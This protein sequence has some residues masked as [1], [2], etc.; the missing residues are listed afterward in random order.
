MNPCSA[1]DL[2][3]QNSHPVEIGGSLWQELQ[4]LSFGGVVPEPIRGQDDHIPWLDAHVVQIRILRGGD[5]QGSGR[6]RG[7]SIP[8]REARPSRW[9]ARHADEVGDW[10]WRRR[11]DSG[12]RYSSSLSLGVYFPSCPSWPPV[13]SVRLNPSTLCYVLR[14]DKSHAPPST[15]RIDLEPFTLQMVST[16]QRAETLCWTGV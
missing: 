2:G 3:P 8:N 15:R 6:L 13:C 11:G 10:M 4:D 5:R 16:Q 9:D 1:P 14:S 7:G 12:E